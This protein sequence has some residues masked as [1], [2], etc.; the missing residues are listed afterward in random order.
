MGLGWMYSCRKCGRQYSAFP[1]SGMCGGEALEKLRSDILAGKY[2]AEHAAYLAAHP[3][4]RCFAEKFL[5]TCP[6]C[7]YWAVEPDPSLYEEEEPLEVRFDVR[8]GYRVVRPYV[9]RCPRCGKVL[10]RKSE[11]D[12]PRQMRLP[13]PDCGTENV[14][15]SSGIWD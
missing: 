2:G 12:L 15:W 9:Q 10:I 7:G 11:Y 1:G 3:D 8:D 13:C 6:D 14:N 4:A 5:Y